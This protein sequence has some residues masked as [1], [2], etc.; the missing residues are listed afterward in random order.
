MV[1]SV[2]PEHQSLTAQVPLLPLA[3]S[4]AR[5]G[6]RGAGCGGRGRGRS[7]VRKPGVAARRA[8]A[9]AA[10]PNK[11]VG[12]DSDA[13]PELVSDSGEE[14]EGSKVHT[15]PVMRHGEKSVS[16]ERRRSIPCH[17]FPKFWA[18]AG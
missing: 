17:C 2:F 8:A 14:L 9:I 5:G 6:H 13:S 3:P 11:S 12:V 4:S 16:H 7:L 1:I 10:G 15:V 18:S